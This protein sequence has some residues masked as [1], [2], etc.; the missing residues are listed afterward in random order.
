MLKPQHGSDCSS[1]FGAIEGTSPKLTAHNASAPSARASN[2]SRMAPPSRDSAG[3]L[4]RRASTS[5]R[6]PATK[7][8][9]ASKAEV[10]QTRSKTLAD[11]ARS[12]K[13][14][15]LPQPPSALQSP[16]ACKIAPV[17]ATTSVATSSAPFGPLPAATR[18][19]SS[20]KRSCKRPTRDSNAWRKSG[21][22]LLPNCALGLAMHEPAANA[23][24]TPA[25]NAD[26]EASVE[27]AF[28][29]CCCC[30]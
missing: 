25:R 23:P 19:T 27:Q 22:D 24:V 15:E 30:C 12:S 18:L 20:S 6:S 13:A 14:S 7:R 16:R 1:A 28:G 10:A 3:A 5:I 29:E 26:Q 21:S 2:A 11:K 8:T 9:T 4:G 17:S